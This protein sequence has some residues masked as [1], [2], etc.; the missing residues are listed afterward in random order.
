M[1]S[2]PDVASIQS[3]SAATDAALAMIVLLAFYMSAQRVFRI[4]PLVAN[5]V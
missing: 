1:K 3:A 5:R 4:D 2:T